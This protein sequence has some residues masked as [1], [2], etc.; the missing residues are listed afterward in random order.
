MAFIVGDE[1]EIT[2]DRLSYDGGR[3]VG[4]HEGFVFF[5]PQTAPQEKVLVKITQLKKNFGE[6]EVVEIL[7]KSPARR[8]PPCA[9][10]NQCGGCVWQHIEYSEQLKQKHGILVHQLKSLLPK[11]FLVPP[12]VASPNEI[13]YRNRVQVHYD[14]N[15]SVFGFFAKGTN[16]VIPTHDCL[17]A[18]EHLF[19]SLETDTD[20]KQT[21]E[22]VKKTHRPSAQRKSLQDLTHL[23]KI[24]IDTVKNEGLNAESQETDNRRIFRPLALTDSEF[25]Q[26]NT[27]VNELL[28]QNVVGQ[29]Q[30]AHNVEHVYDL[31]C[32]SGNLSFPIIEQ[33]HGLHFHGIELNPQAIERAQNRLQTV[34][35]KNQVEFHASAV[36]RYLKHLQKLEPRS[37]MIVDP[38]RAG[39]EDGVN[40]HILRLRPH[41]LIYV[42]CS[43]PTLARDL[44]KLSSYR[45]QS[46]QGFDM[47]PQTEYLETVVTLC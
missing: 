2:I 26:V 13:R 12:V 35:T 21:I 15:S 29:L 28:R 36:H 17:I 47:F 7:E 32:G 45:L 23:T 38:P 6:A 37:A 20:F 42:S 41:L 30:A 27:S 40:E 11:D 25:S 31:Y 19:A 14:L 46:V 16:N 22:K 18:E 33:M 8:E 5:V 44:K 3:G 34:S 39:L 43:L 10:A 4:R 9:I 1:I 24:E